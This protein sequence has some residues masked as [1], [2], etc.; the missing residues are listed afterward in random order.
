MGI[1]SKYTKTAVMEANTGYN[2]VPVCDYE[3]FIESVY[4]TNYFLESIIDKLELSSFIT[5]S[6]LL[7]INEAN[8]K[9]GAKLLLTKIDKIWNDFV[10]LIKKIIDNFKTAIREW[11]EKHNI[12]KGLLKV[13]LKN[14]SYETINTFLKDH[15]DIAKNFEFLV[16]IKDAFSIYRMNTTVYNMENILKSDLDNIN[17]EIDNLT[18]KTLGSNAKQIYSK[19]LEDISECEKKLSS[20]IKSGYDPNTENNKNFYGKFYTNQYKQKASEINNKDDFFDYVNISIYSHIPKN[21]LDTYFI[22][23]KGTITENDF[24]E[25]VKFI[26]NSVKRANEFKIERKSNYNFTCAENKIKSAKENIKFYKGKN[27]FDYDSSTVTSSFYNDTNRGKVDYKNGSFDNNNNN[28]LLSKLNLRL[29]QLHMKIAITSYKFI[30][31]AN[32]Q[33]T[34]L[35]LGQLMTYKAAINAYN[36]GMIDDEGNYVKRKDRQK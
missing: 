32:K 9:E 12:Q 5:E 33:Y 2:N 23:K 14:F 28:L 31:N 20:F 7:S 29:A 8:I 15:P 16:P 36:K 6:S 10:G 4:D 18:E 25:V 17:R 1:Y 22:I 3:T 13:T 26:E 11:Y 19:T 24:N 35:A 30:L 34:F 27:E 21:D